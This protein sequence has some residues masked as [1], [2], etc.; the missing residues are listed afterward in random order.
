MT[1][2]IGDD[3]KSTAFPLVAPRD[4]RCED[5]FSGVSST[6]YLAWDDN[7]EEREGTENIFFLE[8]SSYY[9][10]IKHTDF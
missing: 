4:T 7:F 1:T 9:K 5:D 8:N 6:K 3:V 10:T 2:F